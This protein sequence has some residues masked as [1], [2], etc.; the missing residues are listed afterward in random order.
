MKVDCKLYW[1]EEALKVARVRLLLL[2]AM[3]CSFSSYLA[4][5]SFSGSLKLG[6][7]IDCFKRSV[8]C[9][10]ILAPVGPSKLSARHGSSESQY[11]HFLRAPRSRLLRSC[12]HLWVKD[13]IPPCFASLGPP[14]P[15]QAERTCSVVSSQTPIII[16]TSKRPELVNHGSQKGRYRPLLLRQPKSRNATRLRLMQVVPQKPCKGLGLPRAESGCVRLDSQR[17]ANSNPNRKQNS[18]WQCHLQLLVVCLAPRVDTC[19]DAKWR[20][21]FQR[22]QVR[23]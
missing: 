23:W 14:K 16:T 19:N 9:R 8:H 10:L 2:R 5:L 1:L 22:F 6:D 17:I 11:P 20:R 13:L 12:L 7:R 4:G 21:I 18:S 15:R 3:F